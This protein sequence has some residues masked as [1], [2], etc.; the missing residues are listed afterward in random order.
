VSS[1]TSLGIRF[2]S[3]RYC[4]GQTVLERLPYRILER[5][6]ACGGREGWR[7]SDIEM[8]IFE[9]LIAGVTKINGHADDS[10]SIAHE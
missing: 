3:A 5:A 10:E 6:K 1:P 7:A 2:S 4:S 9:K 8:A